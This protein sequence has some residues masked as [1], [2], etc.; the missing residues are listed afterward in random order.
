MTLHGFIEESNRIEGIHT[1]SPTDMDAHRKFLSEPTSVESLETFVAAVAGARLRTLKGDNV[2]VGQHIAPL[3]GPEIKL[4]L[5]ALIEQEWDPYHMH[6]RYLTLHPFMDGNGRSA[7]ALWLKMTGR[8]PAIGFLHRF[9][10]DTLS[11]SDG[12]KS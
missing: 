3:G 11:H 8:I 6:C 4:R 1:V 12:R 5:E 10:Y 2:R 7:R 9:Y